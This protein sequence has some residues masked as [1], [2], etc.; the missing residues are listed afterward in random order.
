MRA[1]L[2]FVL[3]TTAITFICSAAVTLTVVVVGLASVIFLPLPANLPQPKA[4]E[5]GR[6]SRVYDVN[7]QEIGQFR[8]F[9]QSIPVKQSDIPLVLKQ[10]VVSSEDRN[11]YR[12]GGV[13]I[14]GTFRALYADLVGNRI[15]Q[16]GSTI[17]Q[18]YV[19][20][21]YVGKERTV[22]RKV[23]EAVVASQ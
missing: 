3:R 5:A 12:H 14:R 2:R 18:Q 4:V 19:K 10:A 21:T 9:E 11:F 16:G 23:R 15:A 8:E 7:G 13:D 6:V 20:N 17:T 1:F 22:T